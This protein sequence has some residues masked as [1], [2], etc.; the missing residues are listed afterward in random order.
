MEALDLEKKS[1]FDLIIQQPDIDNIYWYG[2]DPFEAKY[3][4]IISKSTGLKHVNDIKALIK[5][6]NDKDDI[7]KNFEEY[8]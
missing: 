6:W 7:Y 8:K 1:L 4:F 3:Q 5:Y 2:K